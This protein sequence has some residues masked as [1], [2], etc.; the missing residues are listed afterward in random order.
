MKPLP[1]ILLVV[2]VIAAQ[3]APPQ[4]DKPGSAASAASLSETLQWLRGASEEESGDGDTHTT[5]ETSGGHSCNVTITETRVKAGPDFWI[6][7]SFS[8]ADIDPGEIHIENLGQGE[9]G[10]LFQGRSAVDFHT[11]NYIKTIKDS[12]RG[13]F[14]PGGPIL[15]KPDE[16]L[17]SHYTVFTSDWFA[18]RFAKAFK[19][20]VELCGGKPSTVTDSV[21]QNPAEGEPVALDAVVG[22]STP[23]RMDIPAIVKAANGTIVMVIMSDKDGQPIAQGTGFLISKD[24]R[25][26]TNYHVIESG[27]SAIVK[28]PDGAFFAVDGVLAF[29][30]GR[31]IAVIK[32][33]GENFKTLALGN[34]DRVQ[35]GE[36]VVAIGNP[37]SL[38]ST[39]S[40]GIVSGIRDIEE[41]GGKYLQITAPISPGSSGGPLFNL[42]GEVIGITT[43]FL[44]GGENLNFA[45][46]IND[47]KHMLSMASKVRDFPGEGEPTTV[48]PSSPS[49]AS[50]GA[51]TG[52]YGGIVH[53]KTASLSAEFWII[54]NDAGDVITGCMGVRQ[55]LFG[56]GPLT[57]RVDG[58]DVSFVVTS[59]IGKIKF[60][61]QRNNTDVNGTYTVER[62]GFPDQQGNFT[63][64]K[65]KSQGL[66]RDFDTA[67]CPTD[68]EVH[69]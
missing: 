37:L 64:N 18:P 7:E 46:R 9:F 67:N 57:G 20:A 13:P 54:I 22:Q 1:L 43:L 55:P 36:E 53:N 34:S 42:A 39:V 41:E 29:D 35:V 69:K 59:A 58:A 51:S 48:E 14:W 49:H 23:P 8:L 33:H 47:A 52:Q 10:K 17:T 16:I 6:K 25:I 65:S 19:H 66:A 21:E 38:E 50:I 31:D 63:L 28:L 4:K 27:D 2:G 11:T 32:A 15:P 44:K 3:T 12:S 56:S 26:V 62:E 5:F 40:S 45:I 30:K 68:A 61:G 24:G 60:I